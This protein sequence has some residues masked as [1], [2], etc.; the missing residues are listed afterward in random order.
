MNEFN[1]IVQ[2]LVRDCQIPIREL[3]ESLGKPYSTLMREVNPYDKGA[4]LGAETCSELMLLTKNT[5]LLEYVAKRLG[6]T[7]VLR[8]GQDLENITQV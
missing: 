8:E 2:E 7:L 6:F 3:A 1:K 5:S 4:K